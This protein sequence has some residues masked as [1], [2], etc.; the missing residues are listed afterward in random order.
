MFGGASRPHSTP[1]DLKPAPVRICAGSARRADRRRSGFTLIELLVV[2]AIIAILAAMLLPALSKS[3]TK[4]QGIQCMNNGRQLMLC[5]RL[6]SDDNNGGL[7]ASLGQNKAATF[8]GR[9]VWMLGDFTDGNLQEEYDPTVD[10]E[11]G[12]LWSYGKAPSMYKCPADPTTVTVAGV[13][14]PRVRS[15]SMSQVFD[16][17]EWLPANPGPWRTYGKMS[18]I[19]NPVQTFVFVDENPTYMNDGA[20][21]TKCSG[22]PGSGTSGPEIVDIPATYHNKAAGLSFADGHSEIHKWYGHIILTASTD[23]SVTP[24]TGDWTDFCYL[25]LNTTVLR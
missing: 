13:A 15:I 16:F 23:T 22:Y 10:V 8:D 24:G 9:P 21:A 20:F 25:A 1:A 5:W 18:D 14:Y 19:V 3:K 6:Y 17:G 12:P 7:V 4:A 2:I 11:K